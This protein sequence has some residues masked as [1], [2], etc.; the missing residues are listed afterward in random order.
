MAWSKSE[1]V[2]PRSDREAGSMAPC[3][4]PAQH[5]G[6]RAA[7][8]VLE[9]RRTAKNRGR[10]ARFFCIEGQQF[11]CET[12]AWREYRSGVDRR[13]TAARARAPRIAAC[14]RKA[15]WNIAMG[16]TVAKTVG[17]SISRYL[18]CRSDTAAAQA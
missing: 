8:R 10:Q 2:S 7:R 9:I 17:R 11:F 16:E 15:P 14:N 1:A 12:G 3:A 18:P 5:L 6:N 4:W 13:Q